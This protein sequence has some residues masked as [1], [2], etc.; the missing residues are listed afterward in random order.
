MAKPDTKA[1][2]ILYSRISPELHRKLNE[3]LS[4]ESYGYRD[5]KCVRVSMQRLVEDLLTEAIAARAIPA[6]ASKSRS[7]VASKTAARKSVRS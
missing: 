5:G 3:A 2:V 6:V 4:K 7:R 1:T